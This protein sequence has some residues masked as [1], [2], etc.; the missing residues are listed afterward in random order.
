[1]PGPA[2]SCSHVSMHIVLSQ[3]DTGETEEKENQNWA[4]KKKI[5]EMDV[6]LWSKTKQ[7]LR[8]AGPW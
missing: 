8:R 2:G 1:M 4:C 6:E 5:I 3:V 7:N